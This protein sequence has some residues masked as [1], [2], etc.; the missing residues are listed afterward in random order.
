MKLKGMLIAGFCC[1]ELSDSRR[2]PYKINFEIQ[3]KCN[4]HIPYRVVDNGIGL[5]NMSHVTI[6]IIQK[7][8]DEGQVQFIKL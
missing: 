1:S 4:R 7:I 5:Y 8:H 2:C 6:N 3:G